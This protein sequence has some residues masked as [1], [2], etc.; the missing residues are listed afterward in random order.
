MTVTDVE[1]GG[2]RNG[3]I[4]RHKYRRQRFAASMRGEGFMSFKVAELRLRRAEFPAN[5]RHGLPVQQAGNK[6][7]A[8]FHNRTRFPRHRHLPLAKKRK[9]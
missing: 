8:F 4:T 1:I 2:A 7:K 6:A 9:V 5:V 3:K